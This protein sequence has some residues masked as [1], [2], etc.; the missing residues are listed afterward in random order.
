M[1]NL[2][3]SKCEKLC[4]EAI[5]SIEEANELYKKAEK[6]DKEL[7]E[8]TMKLRR[9]DQKQGYAEG[10]NQVLAIIGYKSES[11]KQLSKLL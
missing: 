1:T 6:V 10:I 9:A 5:N 4:K 2:E 8:A 7:H 11:M 3:K